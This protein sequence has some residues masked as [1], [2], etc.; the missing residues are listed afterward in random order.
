MPGV[1]R[2]FQTIRFLI[3]SIFL[4]GLCLMLLAET[5]LT[6]LFS[7]IIIHIGTALMIAS[8]I[9]VIIEFTEIKNFFE[10]RLLEILKGD[11]FLNIL[12]EEKL[13]QFN[14]K[15]MEKMIQNRANNPYYD[16]YTLPQAVNYDILSNIGGVYRDDYHE[17]IEYSILQLSDIDNLGIDKSPIRQEIVKITDTI[18]YRLIAPL[19]KEDAEFEISY[20]WIVKKIP[21]FDKNKHFDLKIL[22]NDET[23][24]L[25]KE[26][27]ITEK[28]DKVEID[29]E[30]K[31]KFKNTIPVEITAIMYEYGR[32]G[33]FSSHAEIITH[34]VTVHFS[35]DQ[36]LEL[37]AEIF[38]MTVNYYEPSI[39][40][41][42][43]SIRYPGWM[44]PGHG[45]FIAWE[46]L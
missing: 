22:V 35:S 13:E 9:G 19:E 8:I 29:Y 23:Q 16:Y 33:S 6:G 26:N 24:S 5:Y 25:E 11:E 41:H 38:G 31:I 43:V 30:S 1:K 37:N 28:S 45:F 2:F 27:F 21:G 17:T 10:E 15:I 3:I 36:P 14:L 32:G 20:D 39:T 34:N 7:S 40:K 4:I 18:T 42:S 46:E 44:L 12:K